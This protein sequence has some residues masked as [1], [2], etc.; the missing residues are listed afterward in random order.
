MVTGRDDAVRIAQ[1]EVTNRTWGIASQFF[2]VHD[3]AT[4]QGGEPAI[5]RI[6]E[7]HEPEAYFV[8][9]P[10]RERPYYFVVV[11]RPDDT[12]RLAV[13]A[14][15]WEAGVQA[16]LRIVSAV[17]SAVEITAQIG[18]T[19]TETHAIGDPI[20]KGVG[21]GSYREYVWR[22]EPQAGLP[23][24]V[25]E[26]LRAV[27]DG[28][29]PAAARIAALRPTCDVQITIVFKGWS[30]DPQF[31][32]FHVDAEPMGRLATL[33]AVLDVDLYALRTEDGRGR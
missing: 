13:S 12:G 9:F 19:P 31:G 32:G 2:A 15:Y 22:F 10:I 29:E 26:K 7:V 18:V 23:G 21:T 17:R 11:V 33:G 5:A 4:A 8:Y 25:E 16:Y 6:D 14:M 3:V 28:V 30:G 27:L 20:G 24:S 1:A